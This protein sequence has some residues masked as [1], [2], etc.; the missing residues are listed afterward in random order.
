MSRIRVS[1]AL[2]R[3]TRT[4]VQAAPAG[5]LTEFTDVFIYDMNDRQYAALVVVLTLLFGWGQVLVE[6]A[7]GV[8]FL[9]RVPTPPQKAEVPVIDDNKAPNS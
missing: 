6:N 3:P 2:A 5:A 8:G 1:E 4:L 7:K 9:R